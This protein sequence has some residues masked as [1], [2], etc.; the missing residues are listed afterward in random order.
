[1]QFFTTLVA[2]ATVAMASAAAISTPSNP[3]TEVNKRAECLVNSAS[4]GVWHEWGLSRFRTKFSGENTD[5]GA[6]CGYW[7]DADLCGGASNVQCWRDDK[8]GWMV[9]ASFVLGLGG[10]KQYEGCVTNTRNKWI[11]QTGCR[12]G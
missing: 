8:Q 6:Y 9:D 2:A 3:L 4:A 11:T 12:T 5:V 7:K 10:D 1:M